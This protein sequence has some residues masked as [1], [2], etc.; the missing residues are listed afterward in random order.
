MDQETLS[1]AADKFEI[2]YNW[3][4]FPFGIP[5]SEHVLVSTFASVNDAGHSHTIPEV[6]RF[7][8][9]KIINY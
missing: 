7:F 2:N 5:S 4:N 8:E 6:K 3:E 1:S 9:R